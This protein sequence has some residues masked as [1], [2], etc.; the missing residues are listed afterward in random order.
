MPILGANSSGGS[1]PSAPVIGSATDGGTGTTA[2]VAFTPSTYIGK[3]TITYTATSSP[4]NLTGTG[5][6]P[7]TVSGLTA[8]TA[9]TFTV[10]GTT[11]YGVASIASSASN[12]VTPV[13]PIAFVIPNIM[14]YRSANF[15][16]ANGTTWTQRTAIDLNQTL[17]ANYAS[18]F[19]KWYATTQD[20]VNFYYYSTDGI[21]WTSGTL[22]TTNNWNKRISVGTDRIVLYSGQ[23]NLVNYSTNGT[24]WTQASYTGANRTVG[25]RAFAFGNGFFLGWNSGGILK[26]SDG[27]NWSSYDVNNLAADGYIMSGLAFGNGR[28]L[29]Y[30]DKVYYSTNTTSWTAGATAYGYDI[31]NTSTLM[32]YHQSAGL[33]MIYKNNYNY[34]YTTPTGATATQRSLTRPEDPFNVFTTVAYTAGT[35][36]TAVFNRNGGGGPQVGYSTNGTTITYGTL[37]TSFT[38]DVGGKDSNY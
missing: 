14:D 34:F 38:G 25:Q 21:N 24:T 29:L 30:A 31:S 5:S 15:T 16:S 11:N 35:V 1:R 2:S 32:I 7:I 8:G 26:S 20:G 17:Y 22:A 23:T 6:S 36:N 37:P 33:F 27:A 12:S 18:V 13:E 19:S 3:G 28:F 9:Y 4:G 10:R